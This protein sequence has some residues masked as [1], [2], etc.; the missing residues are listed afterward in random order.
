MNVSDS[1][2]D[3]GEEALERNVSGLVQTSAQ[4]SDEVVHKEPAL[5]G[6]YIRI[7]ETGELHKQELPAESKEGE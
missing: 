7:V 2:D 3:S 1:M 5:G 4:N 6:S